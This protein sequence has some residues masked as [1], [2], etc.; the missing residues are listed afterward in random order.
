[1]CILP[2]IAI[3]KSCKVLYPGLLAVLQVIL[4]VHVDE[5]WVFE[6]LV[7]A[8]ALSRRLF[9][10]FFDEVLEI[11][12]PPSRVNGRDWLMNDSLEELVST[13]DRMK[14]WHSCCQLMSKAAKGPHINFHRVLDALSNLRADPVWRAT[15][16]LA[17]L[18][19]FGEKD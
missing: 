16:S 2:S 11:L 14:G 4:V 5:E 15:L 1:M 12:R 19:L 17:P 7:N 8:E 10:A 6:E 18:G 3:L 13:A 9:Q